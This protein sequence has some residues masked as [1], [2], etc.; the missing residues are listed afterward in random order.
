MLWKLYINR[1]FKQNRIKTESGQ[2]EIQMCGR[3]EWDRETKSAGN[4]PATHTHTN[5]H[6]RTHTQTDRHTR[7]HKWVTD[8]VFFLFFKN[9]PSQKTWGSITCRDAAVGND[10]YPEAQFKDIQRLSHNLYSVCFIDV[11]LSTCHT[12]LRNTELRAL[13]NL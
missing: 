2:E 7:A 12:E 5:P 13:I 9:T 10:K 11:Q 6:T 4:W 3:Y 1:R 8:R